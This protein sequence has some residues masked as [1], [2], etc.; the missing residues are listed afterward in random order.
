MTASRRARPSGH[1]VPDHATLKTVMP[2]GG[3]TCARTVS[4]VTTPHAEPPPPLSAQYLSP[5]VET[6]KYMQSMRNGHE[7]G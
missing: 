3:G 1:S 2:P 7:L 4:D 6:R 5:V